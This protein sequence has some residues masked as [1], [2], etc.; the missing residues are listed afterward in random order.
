MYKLLFITVL[1]IS[2]I[3][4]DKKIE[5][6]NCSDYKTITDENI[7]KELAKRCPRESGL[8]KQDSDSNPPPPR[9]SLTSPII[10]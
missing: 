8:N 7:K 9:F 5:E 6:F 10:D 2:I 4:C 1:S 3:G